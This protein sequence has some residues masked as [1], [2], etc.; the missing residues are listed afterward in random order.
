MSIC[1]QMVI[2]SLSI[3]LHYFL[4]K[5]SDLTLIGCYHVWLESYRMVMMTSVRAISWHDDAHVC[6]FAIFVPYQL[7][8]FSLTLSFSYWWLWHLSVLTSYHLLSAY[9]I[10]V[11]L[12]HLCLFFLCLHAD[13]ILISK[14]TE[15]FCFQE[16]V[17]LVY[18]WALI[19]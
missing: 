1:A 10:R 5:I 7:H 3:A 2:I 4:T 18:Y 13:P 19:L 17:S 6:S 8:K 9:Y 11:Q 14:V 16:R 15:C 12:V